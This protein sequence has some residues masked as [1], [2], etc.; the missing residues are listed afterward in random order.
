MKLPAHV[1]IGSMKYRVQEMTTEMQQMSEAH[2]LCDVTQ[3]II[4]IDPK[5]DEKKKWSTL[6]HECL[7]GQFEEA[8][9]QIKDGEQEEMLVSHLERIQCLVFRDNPTFIRNLTKVLRG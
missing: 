2:G 5:Q 6:W 3:L 7:H 1:Q 8:P 9:I 4:Y